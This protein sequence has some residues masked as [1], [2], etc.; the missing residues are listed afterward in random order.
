[1]R[2]TLYAIFAAASLAFGASAQ[3][4]I[5][6]VAGGGPDGVPATAANLAYP[7]GIAPGPGNK[8]YIVSAHRVFQVGPTGVLSIVAGTGDH[9]TDK[10]YSVT[11]LCLAS[12]D[13]A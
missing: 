9:R 3:G 13:Q 8:T 7:T 5:G 6:T 4:I 2:R 11:L 1:M 10:P 12:L